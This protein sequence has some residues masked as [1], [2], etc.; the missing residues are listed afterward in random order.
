MTFD[1]ERLPACEAIQ[2]WECNEGKNLLIR[3]VSMLTKMTMKV[4]HI[5]EERIPCSHQTGARTSS[6]KAWKQHVLQ[7]YLRQ[8]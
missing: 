5:Q 3:L 8:P 6:Y 2:K 1:H 4:H 7:A